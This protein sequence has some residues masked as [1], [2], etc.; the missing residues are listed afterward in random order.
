MKRI[1]LVVSLLALLCQ[2]SWAYSPSVGH[3]RLLHLA[4]EALTVCESSPQVF[5]IED[6]NIMTLGSVAMD[7]GDLGFDGVTKQN[8]FNPWHR[9]FNWHFYPL[10]EEHSDYLLVNPSYKNLWDWLKLGYQTDQNRHNKLMYLGGLAHFIEDM[11]NPSHSVPAFHG[12][13]VKDGIDLIEPDYQKIKQEIKNGSFCLSQSMSQTPEEIRDELVSITVKTLAQSIPGCPGFYWSEFYQS[14]KAGEYF[15]D[16]IQQPNLS[17]FSLSNQH[18]FLIGM[19]GSLYS[20]KD[21]ALKC[22]FKKNDSRYG[23][24]INQLFRQAIRADILLLKNMAP[25][26]VAL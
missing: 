10:V 8:P 20:Q 26:F 5:S 6:I 14:P 16:Y 25:D 12:P 9:L 4:Y 11:A 17:W 22:E 1:I 21:S 13:G 2:N 19:E 3:S 15:G 24:F 7:E 23:D 18:T